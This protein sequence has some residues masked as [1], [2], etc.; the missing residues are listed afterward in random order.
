MADLDFERLKNHAL[1]ERL[2][3][4]LGV[5]YE[6]RATLGGKGDVDLARVEHWCRGALQA[7]PLLGKLAPNVL[8]SGGELGVLPCPLCELP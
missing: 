8:G 3:D 1:A 2:G 4:P 7:F 5:E 6:R